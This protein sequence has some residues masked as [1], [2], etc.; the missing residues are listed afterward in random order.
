VH[1]T[2]FHGTNGSWHK[3]SQNELTIGTIHKNGSSDHQCAC[4]GY[5]V[6]IGSKVEA[7]QRG[8]STIVDDLDL[9]ASIL[10][11]ISDLWHLG[12]KGWSAVAKQ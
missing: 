11:S 3:F 7:S 5:N 2:A 4:R 1:T 10:L 6:M 8:G 12:V 9:A